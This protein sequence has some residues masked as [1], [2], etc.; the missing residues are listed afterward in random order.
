MAFFNEKDFAIVLSDLRGKDGQPNDVT[1]ENLTSEELAPLLERGV[2]QESINTILQ[3]DKH[4]TA[5]IDAIRHALDFLKDGKLTH[6]I[7]DVIPHT[8]TGCEEAIQG[9]ANSLKELFGSLLDSEAAV[10]EA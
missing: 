10:E 4:A 7:L 8:V 3:G 5:L 1:K 9:T 2:S 6:R